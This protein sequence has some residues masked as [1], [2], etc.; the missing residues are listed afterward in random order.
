MKKIMRKLSA[1][2]LKPFKYFRIANR[3]RVHVLTRM[4]IGN[5]ASVLGQYMERH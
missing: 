4:R 3:N 2:T 1:A 5:V